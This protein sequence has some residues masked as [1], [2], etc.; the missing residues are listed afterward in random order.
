[1]KISYFISAADSALFGFAGLW[2]NWTNARSG[3]GLQTTTIVTAPANTFLS[4]LHHR[5]PVVV[6]PENANRWLLGDRMALEEM[7]TDPPELCAWP[8]D[9]RIGN[10]R[11]DGPEL[12]QPTENPI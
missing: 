4:Q 12:I 3:E 1:V 7:I 8:V 9:P 11:N 10:P 5:M 6:R 2:E